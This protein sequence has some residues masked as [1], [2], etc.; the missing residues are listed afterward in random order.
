MIEQIE[1]TILD[2]LKEKFKESEIDSFPSSFENYNFTS[3]DSCILVRFE[4]SD[5]AP[6]NSITKVNTE[7]TYNFTVF[8]GKR[9]TRVHSD[10]YPFLHEIK[11]VLNGLSIMSK[12]LILSKR[13]FEED[14]SGDL[15]YSYGVKITLPVIDEYKDLSQ[16]NQIIG[17]IKN[18]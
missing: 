15:W 8:I 3:Y 5:I 17:V 7:E 13:R 9:F 4:N 11:K 2:A 14:I 10:C 6:Q 16:G 1:N 18:E 12:R